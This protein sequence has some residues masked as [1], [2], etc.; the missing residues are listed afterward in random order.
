MPDIDP[1]ALARLQR[2][3]R[4]APA[5]HP[6]SGVGCGRYEKAE[7]TREHLSENAIPISGNCASAAGGA[8]R[9]GDSEIYALVRSAVGFT[10]DDVAR[11][12][13]RRLE[14]AFGRLKPI[15][16]EMVVLHAIE[17]RSLTKIAEHLGLTKKQAERRLAA[18]IAAWDKE[19]CRVNRP[20]KS[21]WGCA[22]KAILK[23]A[24]CVGL[25]MGRTRRSK[26]R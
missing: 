14:T 25:G 8:F 1:I 15:H 16:R 17:K 24:P 7:G 21:L 3:C 13:L 19:V 9:P 12:E 23:S 10:K 26:Q 4:P 22:R 5:A 2:A 20:S 6:A 11:E 18:T